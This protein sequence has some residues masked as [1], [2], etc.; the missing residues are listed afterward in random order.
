MELTAVFNE[1]L[2]KSSLIIFKMLKRF[3]KKLYDH[4]FYNN[5][6]VYSVESA[7]KYF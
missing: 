3:F 7:F 6:I 5:Y 1:N 4:T 2:S